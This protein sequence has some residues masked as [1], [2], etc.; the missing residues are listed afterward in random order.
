MEGA[1]LGFDDGSDEL[2]G[3]KLGFDDGRVESDGVKLGC[4]EGSAVEGTGVA[5]LGL[6]VGA[7]FAL[8]EPGAAAAA[9]GAS[10]S[11]RFERVL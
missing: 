5:A 6:V 10:G 11:N 4:N 8:L 9:R 1:K 7:A 3:T 2:E